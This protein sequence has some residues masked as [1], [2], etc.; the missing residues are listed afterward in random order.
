M[1]FVLINKF[2]R[3]VCNFN[4]EIFRVGHWSIKVKILE[5]NGAETCTWARKHAVEKQ[6]DKFEVW[7]VSSHIT[8]E[9]DAIA[10]DGDAGEVKI[11]LFWMHF[12]YHPGVADFP[13][14]M[15]QDVMVVN[16]KEGVSARN[17]FCVGGRTRAYA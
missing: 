6:L 5:V 10:T 2:C 17:P 7:G 11:I 13:P 8:W 15:D 16:K 4:A 12:R 1:K 3:N 14:F 9:A